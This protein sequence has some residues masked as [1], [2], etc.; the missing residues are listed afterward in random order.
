MSGR[1]SGEPHRCCAAGEWD[2]C[3]NGRYRE[4]GIK[5][6]D[7]YGAE[8]WR[9]EAGFVVR[10]PPALGRLGVLMADVSGKGTS[11]AL[12]MSELKGLM[13]ALSHTERSPRQLLQHFPRHAPDPL[14]RRLQHRADVVLPLAEDVDERFTI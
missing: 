1:P 3:R 14:R 8:R 12:Y 13:L 11:A 4:R 5:E 10:V 7:G 9:A 2:Q 6:L